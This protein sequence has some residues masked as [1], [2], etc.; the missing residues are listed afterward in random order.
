MFADIT[1]LVCSNAGPVPNPRTT[2][3]PI[4]LH[5]PHLIDQFYTTLY[6]INVQVSIYGLFNEALSSSGV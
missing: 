4:K 1:K 3:K 2:V 5:P 6:K